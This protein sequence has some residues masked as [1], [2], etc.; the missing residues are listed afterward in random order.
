M[1]AFSWTSDIR[2]ERA[3]TRRCRRR[4]LTLRRDESPRAE[5]IWEI[6]VKKIDNVRKNLYAPTRR[7]SWQNESSIWERSSADGAAN[8]APIAA[9]RVRHSSFGLRRSLGP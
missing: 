3:L 2:A 7:L 1:M 4:R 6:P 9:P 5:P 8:S